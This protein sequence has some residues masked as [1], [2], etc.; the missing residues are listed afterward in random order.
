MSN[1]KKLS[2]SIDPKVNSPTLYHYFLVTSSEEGLRIDFAMADEKK[3]EIT[4]N[5]K[6][7]IAI[8]ADQM[9]QF[10]VEIIRELMNYEEKYHNGKGFSLPK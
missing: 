7:S 10:S 6:E 8:S 3:E 4:L 9:L 2:I 5:V 1:K